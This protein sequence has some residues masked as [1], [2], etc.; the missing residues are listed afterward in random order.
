M[1]PPA[2]LPVELLRVRELETLLSDL[3]ADALRW[4]SGF[5]AGL[6]AERARQSGAS[7]PAAIP[8]GAAAPAPVER[9]TVLY[10][11]QT[12]N[13]RR[14]AEKLGQALTNAGLRASVLAAGDYALKQF[15][16]DRFLCVIA[17]THGDG[18]PPDDARALLDA[19]SG[20]RAPKLDHLAFAVLALGDSSYPQF[21]ETGRVF[22][23]RLGEL[24][25]RRLL[26]R[27]DCDVDFESKA[28]TWVQQ[29]VE[30]LIGATGTLAAT[31]VT[32]DGR[33]PSNPAVAVATRE[34][35]VEVE[36][37]V[38]QRITASG[39]DKDVR[40]VELL[41]P[42]GQFPYQAGDALGIWLD[43]PAALIDATL[44]ATGLDPAET[45]TLDGT[46][47]PLREWLCRHRELTR[48][49][50]ALI[51][52]LA[53]LS[54]D[55]TLAAL[56]KPDAA[57]RLR[58]QFKVWQVPDLLRAYPVQWTGERLVRALHP[59]S[60]R[61]YSIASAPEE[62]GDEVHITVAVV[63][64]LHDGNRHVG[65]VS[66]QVQGFA[67]GARFQAF[68]ESN[69][70]F[71]LPAD[72][73]VDVIMIGPGTGV[74]PFRGF[75]QA[76]SAQGATGRNWLFFGGRHLDNDFLYQTEWLSAV[77]KKALTRLDVA[78]SR[79]TA[80]KIY[81]QHRLRER[82]ADVYQWLEAG[83]HVYVCGDAERMAPDVHAAL[84]D[85]V[86]T[87]GGRSPQDA[88]AYIASLASQRR[89]LRDV[90]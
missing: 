10:A 84:I 6:S 69:S 33:S 60:P 83:A 44:A 86:A 58:A 50:R 1:S 40:H 9:V 62:V 57:A 4:V 71:R 70:R 68:I 65:A 24:G 59:L 20:R 3:D 2:R 76:R 52:R 48:V 26:E 16:D 22:D 54:G 30:V 75:V 11:S 31:A 72:P 23:R 79:D 13:S 80:E 85:I 73:S 15:A 42:P 37:A 63:D 88:E 5:V 17:S 67:P 29:S 77:K 61:L 27:V 49:A 32:A 36:V 35:P 45:V 43:N 41:V 53:A 90:Y 81:V 12:G 87:A 66:S 14:V 28:Q 64:D 39:A 19:L 34:A 78:F 25:G 55:D 18:E 21:C 7:T 89:Y 56:L 46:S 38:N 74:A 82:S 51:E 8:Q 47:R